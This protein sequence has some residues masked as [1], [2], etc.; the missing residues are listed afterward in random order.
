MGFSKSSSRIGAICLM[1]LSR[2][3]KMLLRLKLFLLLLIIISSKPIEQKHAQYLED[4][5]K[6]TKK[7]INS[8]GNNF[9]IL[10]YEMQDYVLKKGEKKI[11]DEHPIVD[12][13]TSEKTKENLIK[14][15][16]NF[17]KNV[18]FYKKRK[19]FE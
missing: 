12:F 2:R 11:A 19:K 10:P 9:D 8:F 6:S 7:I 17:K 4:K 3:L 16:L 5:K 15:N 18:N 14:K 1:I 13:F